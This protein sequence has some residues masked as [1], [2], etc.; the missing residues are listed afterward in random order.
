[1]AYQPTVAVDFDGVLHSYTSGWTGALPQDPPND[2]A[3]DFIQ[4]ILDAGYLAVI[5]SSRASNIG[6]EAAILA[7]LRHWGFPDLPITNKKPMAIAYVDDR[8]V[9]FTNNNWG[10]CFARIKELR[11]S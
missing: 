7:W 8:A 10:D 9:A 5:Y 6:G 11:N 1:M 2:G 3:L 4:S